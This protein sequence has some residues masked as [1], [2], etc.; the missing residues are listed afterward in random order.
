MDIED[1]SKIDIE[2]CSF[3][4]NFE[5]RSDSF[6]FPKGI[7]TLDDLKQLGK[8][9]DMCPYFLAR[10]FLISADVIVYNYNYLLDPKIAN[11]V[12]SELQQDCIVV[13][14]ECHNIDNACIEALSMNLNRKSLELAGQNLRTLELRLQEEKKRGA[15]R[16]A[17]EYQQLVRGL[18][19]Q[20]TI[21]SENEMLSHPILQKDVLKESI[22]GSIRKA[23]HFVP[24]LR[25]LIVYLK[26]KLSST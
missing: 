17:K 7:F 11:L 8:Q 18:A 6:K 15:E 9:T 22:P 26:E 2:R 13:F 12:S 16:L 3:Y 5:E 10:R 24:M 1:L 20:N 19:Q 4:D 21:K 25:K 14:D 23:E